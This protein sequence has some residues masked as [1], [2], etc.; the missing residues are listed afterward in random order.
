M[1]VTNTNI[2]GI[3]VSTLS[4][5]ETIKV[6]PELIKRYEREKKAQYI[7]TLNMDF[8]SN[9]FHTFS[10]KVKNNELYDTLKNADLV[11][12]DGMPIVWFGKMNNS[13]IHERVTG[14]DMIFDVARYAS[15][16][17]HKVYYIGESTQLCRKAHNKLK[18]IYPRLKSAG[19]ASPMVS[20]EGEILDDDELLSKINNSGAKILL[21]GLGNP[22][23][24]MFFRRYKDQLQVPVSIGIGG[25]YNFVTGQVNRAPKLLQT[26]GMEWLYRL[27]REPG[28]LW[29]RYFRQ[30]LLMSSFALHGRLN[31]MQYLSY[32]VFGLTG[33]W[34][35]LKG[36]IKIMGRFNEKML[37]QVNR[38]VNE[39]SFS[40]LDIKD[41]TVAEGRTLAVLKKT[42][43]IHQIPLISNDLNAEKQKPTQWLR[44]TKS[45]IT[46]LM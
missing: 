45:M 15:L 4:Q 46:R 41:M 14:A 5:T 29:K 22:K 23:Q 25:T 44:R 16:L 28:K 27:C 12:A 32:K 18:T 42:C 9:C 20:N 13:R 24:E 6:F 11:T 39:T 3:P 33:Q 40:Q 1:I 17:G 31:I 37:N 26:M 38:L 34:E 36:S 30:I 19:Y 35:G 7:A 43:Q 10:L 21:L 2:F 8:L